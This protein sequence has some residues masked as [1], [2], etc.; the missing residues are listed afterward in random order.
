MT[1]AL[2]AVDVAAR[3]VRGLLIPFGELS[4]PS[5]SGA[6]PVMFSANTALDLPADPMVATLYDNEHDRF[7]PRGRGAAFERTE[8]GIVA[9]FAIARTPEGDALLT[10]AAD[11][12]QPRPKLSAEIRGL[13]RR[14]ADAIRG[15]LTGAS[16]VTE[17]AF[18][19]AHLFA[20]ADAITEET[21]APTPPA[22]TN[23]RQEANMTTPVLD[24][25]GQTPAAPTDN[26]PDTSLNALYAATA[27]GTQEERDRFNTNTGELFALSTMTQAN[28]AAATPP[29]YLGELWRRR[30]YNRRFVPLLNQAPLLAH[31]VYGWQWVEGKEPNVG[32][33]A[34]GAADVPSNVLDTVQIPAAAARIAGG[35][36]LDR[37][38]IDFN[39]QAVIASYYDHMTEDYARKS[40]AKA[41]A[42]I[43][44][45]ANF[46]VTAPGAVPAGI[47]K[48]LAAIVDG[49]LDVIGTENTPGFA[50]VDAPLWRDIIL[51]T[52][53]AGVLTYLMAAMGLEEGQLEGFKIRPATLGVAAEAGKVVMVGAKES[54]TFYELPGVPIRVEG[55]DAHHGTIDPAVYGY[56][57][58]IS[59]NAKALRKVLTV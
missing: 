5:I 16:I 48:G 32:D 17:G 40:D 30:P 13:V 56:W 59:N 49:A 38:F 31:Q 11:E 33:Y 15:T 35:H 9:T 46:T 3:T 55:L 6:E 8:A 14:G 18:A 20:V 26:A 57:A 24:A 45:A 41:L 29:A 54:A 7:S 10:R 2:F 50:L 1:D 39:D 22:T 4:R 44:T 47:P 37:K 28:G 25:L 12:T 53:K 42:T 51:S 58:A 21:P 52:D 19:G 36:K 27:G 23:D 34:G 43:L